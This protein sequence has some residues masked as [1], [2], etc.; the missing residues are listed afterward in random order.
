MLIVSGQFFQIVAY[1]GDIKKGKN[2][3]VFN[4]EQRERIRGETDWG[5]KKIA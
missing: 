4:S 2:K 5:V 3:L 1:W